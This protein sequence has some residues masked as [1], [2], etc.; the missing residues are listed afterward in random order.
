MR[1]P[2]ALKRRGAALWKELN[3]DDSPIEFDAH[4][5]PI[6][7]ELCRA[8]DRIDQLQEE[9]DESGLMID[10]SAGQKV[11]HPAVGEMRQQQVLVA[12]LTGQLNIASLDGGAAMVTAISDQARRAVNSRW[13]K[14]KGARRA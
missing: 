13:N 5:I 14:S 12:R 2:K 7:T 1:A 6:L 4:E 8:V 3:G 10:G 11:L 9:I